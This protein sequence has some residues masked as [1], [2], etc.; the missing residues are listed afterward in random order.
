MMLLDYS[1]IM[2]FT[3]Q[4]SNIQEKDINK[5]LKNK[6]I[7]IFMVWFIWELELRNLL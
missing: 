5:K 2:I 6:F 1:L 3:I 4:L 7:H